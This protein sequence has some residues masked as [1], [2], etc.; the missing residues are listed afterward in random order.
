MTM[1]MP[2]IQRKKKVEEKY[3]PD[4]FRV[5]SDNAESDHT[6][7]RALPYRASFEPHSPLQNST[8][9]NSWG[10]NDISLPLRSTRVLPQPLPDYRRHNP[11]SRSCGF[12][13][14]NVR[15]LCEP[16]C[17]VHTTEVQYEEGKWWPARANPGNLIVPPYAEDTQYRIDYNYR[18]GE[19]PKGCGRH[20]ANINREPALGAIPVN[21]LKERDGSQRLYKE[22]LSFEHQYNSRKDPNYP[23][24][25]KRHGAFVWD[26]MDPLSQKKFIDYYRRLEEEERRAQEA[27]EEGPLKTCS[28]PVIRSSNHKDFTPKKKPVYVFK[29]RGSNILKWEDCQNAVP[30][31]PHTNVSV[32]NKRKDQKVTHS[33]DKLT[34]SNLPDFIEHNTTDTKETKPEYSQD[35][36]E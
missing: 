21:L 33:L 34:A 22:G 26:R 9:F 27:G 20:T 7:Y 17:N 23:I 3:N 19:N 5:I 36:T 24:R 28:A 2:P 25:G 18:R 11:Q 32:E 35:L 10:R 15:L 8:Q 12:L 6:K 29:R 13:D 16:V 14:K 31:T 30:S 1:F 4:T